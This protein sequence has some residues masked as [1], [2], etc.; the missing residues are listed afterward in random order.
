MEA[1]HQ[2]EDQHPHIKI[3]YPSSPDYSNVRQIYNLAHTATPL[4]I[5]AAQDATEVSQVV[6]FASANKIP[7][8]V[9]SGG[10]DA[11]GRSIVQDAIVIDIR[12][13]NSVE[14]NEAT[15]TATIGGGT[16]SGKL[17]AD[18]C[19]QGLVTPTGTIPWVGYV[20]WATLGGYGPWAGIHGLG[21]DQITGA[22][23][24]NAHGDIVNADEAVLK[25]I[26]G[27]GGNFGVIVEMTVKVYP[28]EKVNSSS[29]L[30][31]DIS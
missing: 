14:V 2:F 28:F 21:I 1:I 13:L 31:I 8:S 24:V 22:K 27:A 25:G 16:S 26:R 7:I 19:K 11:H 5:V 10:N 3:H 9:R 18:L 23:L 17:I 15:A 12:A 20:G 29:I 6:S 4:A 30:P